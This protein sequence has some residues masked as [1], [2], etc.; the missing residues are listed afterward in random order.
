MAA[1]DNSCESISVLHANHWVDS[2]QNKKENIT[3]VTVCEFVWR[4]HVGHVDNKLRL[5]GVH[6]HATLWRGEFV[7]QNRRMVG[8]TGKTDSRA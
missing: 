3:K 5:C 6:G 7:R 4:Q 2:I 1:R 8:Q